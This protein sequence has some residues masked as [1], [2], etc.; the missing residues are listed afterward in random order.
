MSA[1]EAGKGDD[2]IEPP[3]TRTQGSAPSETSKGDDPLGPPTA[4]TRTQGS[5]PSEKSKGDDPQP[6]QDQA[7]EHDLTAEEETKRK[8][9]EALAAKQ[10]RKGEDHIDNP[11]QHVQAQGPVET[12][13]TFRRK[14]G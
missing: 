2:P 14:T 4:R 8:F 11:Q 12:K 10:G 9:R 3:R 1:R 6:D 7:P 5:A 13:R